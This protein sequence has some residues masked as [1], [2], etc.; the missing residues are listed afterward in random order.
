[1]KMK[2]KKA[3]APMSMIILLASSV[4]TFAN[5]MPTKYFQPNLINYTNTDFDIQNNITSVDQ[6]APYDARSFKS[7]SKDLRTIIIV[8]N[9]YKYE[10]TISDKGQ[11][12]FPSEPFAT[13][14]NRTSSDMKV[15]DTF[16]KE[17]SV[18]LNGSL[19]CEKEVKA[20]IKAQFGFE[21]SFKDTFSRKIAV[22]VP[23]GKS[24]K[25][26]VEYQKLVVTEDEYVMDVSIGA[27]PGSYKYNKTRTKTIY[28]P[29]GL[30]Y[31]E[32]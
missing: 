1:M 2:F 6:K 21:Y 20:D 22:T 16:S 8:P 25:V 32:Q 3:I 7:S 27:T 4:P 30:T 24:L 28:K 12:Y 26:F 15:D 10:T 29:T 23:K 31:I 11:Y 17:A 9:A 14:T 5:E 19:I 18:K 13:V